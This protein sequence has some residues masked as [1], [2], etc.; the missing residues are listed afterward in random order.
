MNKFQLILL[1]TS[2]IFSSSILANQDAR[3]M[4]QVMKGLKEKVVS[5][6]RNVKPS[7]AERQAIEKLKRKVQLSNNTPY[8]LKV[9]SDV[10][11]STRHDFLTNKKQTPKECYSSQSNLLN[12]VFKQYYR[13]ITEKEFINCYNITRE[14]KTSG[15]LN[16][17]N[18]IVQIKKE[19]CAPI[20]KTEHKDVYQRAT[21]YSKCLDS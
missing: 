3:N 17:E 5:Y 14:D 11:P 20:L 2:I 10:K 7:T 6:C 18:C 9:E 4:D 21:I 15:I 16:F 1:S 8:K 12:N 13:K 19:E